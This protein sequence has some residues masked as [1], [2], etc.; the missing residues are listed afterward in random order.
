MPTDQTKFKDMAWVLL[1]LAGLFEVVWAVGL[2]QANGF[3]RWW[4]SV[5]TVGAMIVSFVL[6]GL[7]LKSVPV[8]TAYGVWVGIGTVGTVLLGIVLLGES[9]SLIRLAFVGLIIVGI[10]GLKLTT[11]G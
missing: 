11:P 6:L 8:G 1:V 5:Y 3:S 4:P 7:A 9:A 10:V 2:K